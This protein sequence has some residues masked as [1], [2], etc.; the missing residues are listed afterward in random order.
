[1]KK[2]ALV[3]ITL[4]L[5]ACTAEPPAGLAPAATETG[6]PVVVFDP[7]AKPLPEIPLPNDLAT[8]LD[9]D[10]PATGRRINVSLDAPTEMEREVRRKASLANGFGINSPI[11]VSFTSPLDLADLKARHQHNLDFKDD[12]VFVID[13]TPGSP[14]YLDPVPLDMGQGNFPVTVK[15]FDMFF[16]NDPRAASTNVL[17]ETVGE[18]V[19]GDGMLDPW[20]DTDFDGVLDMP[21]VHPD[22]ADPVD[23]LLT[24]YEKETDTLI[25]RPLL[26]LRQ[27]TTYAVVLTKRLV[28]LE[29]VPVASPFPYINH[30]SQ[31]DALAP[32]EKALH[33]I[34]W[35]MD[36]EDVAFA[37]TFTTQ[38]VTRD[39]E[40]LRAGLNGKGAF[41]WLAPHY[42]VSGVTL[43]KISGQ[44]NQPAYLARLGQ[45]ADTLLPIAE[46][47][48]DN[49]QAA[50]ALVEDLKQ[51][52]YL[53]AGRFRVPYFLEDKD[54]IA[55]KSYPADDDEDFQ[56]DLTSGDAAVGERWV[57]FICTIP[58]KAEN[59][60]NGREPICTERRVCHGGKCDEEEVCNCQPYPVVIYGHSYGGMKFEALGFAGRHAAFGLATCALDAPGHGL[61]LATLPIDLGEGQKL[62]VGEVLAPYLDSYDIPGV[63]SVLSDH[64][65]RDLNNDGIPD[66]GADFWT[67]DLF[68]TRDVV[69]QTVV[70]HLQFLRILRSFDGESVLPFD[71]DGDGAVD[72]AG[73]FDG[74]GQVDLGGPEVKYTAWG[75]SLGGLVSP[76]VA[77]LEPAIE[78]VAP[79]AG[80]AG[81]FD[82]AM[83]ATNPGIPEAMFLPLLGPFVV[84]Y[85]LGDGSSALAFLV[86]DTKDN[87]PVQSL[88]PFHELTLK[89][90][91]L[92]VLRNLKN[93]GM[94]WAVVNHEGGFRLAVPTDALGASDKRVTL[95]MDPT[96]G[97]I[98]VKTMDTESLGDPL[99][100]E[101]YDGPTN[102]LVAG[103]SQFGNDV[104]YQGATY[105]A[106]A[107]LVALA[108]GLG[109]KR[110]TPELRRYLSFAS[111]IMDPGDPVGYL[112]HLRGDPLAV[113]A[114]E[115]STGADPGASLLVIPSA[116]DTN[117]PAA[118]GI[119]Q[120]RAAGIIELFKSSSRYC[121]SAEMCG[122]D[123]TLE[124]SPVCGYVG[125]CLTENQ[126]LTHHYVYEGLFNRKRFAVPPWD[127]YREVVFDVDDLD[128]GVLPWPHCEYPN[129]ET[130]PPCTPLVP[131][132]YCTDGPGAPSL[133]EWGWPPLRAT[134]KDKKSGMRIFLGYRTDCHGIEPPA[135]QRQPDMHTYFV[136]LV[137]NYFYRASLGEEPTKDTPWILDDPC[138]ADSSCESFP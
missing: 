30:A 59:C 138:L 89:P 80:G 99:K 32:L 18:D 41:G 62:T 133:K 5:A 73:D 13:V 117:V 7:E 115:A 9:P 108:S 65:S 3:A 56:I 90:G 34:K 75:Q 76:M 132:M 71:V 17:F 28:G 102:M 74:D 95:D 106:G 61:D 43:H 131:G 119:A 93:G 58:K 54:G 116:G 26:P 97:K 78:A 8:R 84:G 123:V 110:G 10:E 91:D 107:P 125:E 48:V 40:V 21:N 105:G 83:R 112:P 16:M 52:D 122:E 135:P 101:I 137:S 87:L 109:L 37:W 23:A 85:S 70:D 57:P 94:D 22:D 14:S 113:G 98:P 130:A 15:D 96:G 20:E 114:G 68:H 64:R 82:L 31:N 72:L 46:A 27:E 24:F 42:P 92:A 33:Q 38:S 53:V 35:G 136:N 129:G 39:L 100:L 63:M 104:T 55:T 118:V 69:R 81:L 11:T 126:V 67:H 128:D 19:N 77:A 25:L 111:M 66:A 103:I 134:T 124:R 6:A 4:I 2:R 127:D 36:L 120:A 88:L 121:V 50:Q 86:Q 45:F 49:P 60:A 1:M 29:G 79:S 47:A 51:I 44:G 12:A